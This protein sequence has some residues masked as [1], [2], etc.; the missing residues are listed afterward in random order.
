[1]KQEIAQ[2]LAIIDFAM[3]KLLRVRKDGD[4]I[5]RQKAKKVSRPDESLRRLVDDM[6]HTMY[7]G[8]S[9]GIGLAAPQVGVSLRL[10]VV[11]MQDDE[12]EPI[13]LVN[14]EI[15]KASSDMV[16]GTEG[17]LSVP[18]LRG[19]VNRHEWV[20]V[21]GRNEFG[22][23]RRFKAEG[24]FARCLQHEIDHLN[25]ILFIDHISRLK[26]GLF[27]RRLKKQAAAR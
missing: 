25:G 27:L 6:F 5:L 11:D 14:P 8:D 17:C 16:V 22:H 19:D 3:A 21:K 12:T 15:V 18:G 7:N 26:R 20:T 4:P 1:M 23:E 10:I 2:A 24:W 13:A 9:R